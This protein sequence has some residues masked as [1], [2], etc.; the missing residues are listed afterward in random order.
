[1]RP[2][3]VKPIMG[4]IWIVTTVLVAFRHF[5][6]YELRIWGL[7]TKLQAPP[8]VVTT[9]VTCE[10]EVCGYGCWYTVT[11][12]LSRWFETTPDRITSCP[13]TISGVEAPIETAGGGPVTTT[14][15]FREGC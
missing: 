9:F 5:T 12:S 13:Y 14:V 1:M 11:C 6:S 2:V 3:C 10:N 15:P 8:A 4:R 7:T